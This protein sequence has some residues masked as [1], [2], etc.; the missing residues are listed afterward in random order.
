MTLKKKPDSQQEKD[1]QF[2]LVN[3]YGD[4]KFTLFLADKPSD[5]WNS[6]HCAL[7]ITDSHTGGFKDIYSSE[8]GSIIS[9]ITTE[10]LR[11]LVD[12][13]KKIETERNITHSFISENHDFKLALEN[14]EDIFR[15][16]AAIDLFTMNSDKLDAGHGDSEISLSFNCTIRQIKDFYTELSSWLGN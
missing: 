1:S 13:F 14:T 15:V 9:D 2:S 7:Q 3:D 16:T 10:D 8:C 4:L 11:E 5:N 12:F 6:Y